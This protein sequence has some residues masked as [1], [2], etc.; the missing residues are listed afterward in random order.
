MNGTVYLIGLAQNDAEIVKVTDHARTIKGVRKVV[1]HV[2]L[3]TDPRRR[4]V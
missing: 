4:P 1:S 2:W 3:K